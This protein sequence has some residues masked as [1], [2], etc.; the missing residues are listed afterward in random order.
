MCLTEH[1]APGQWDYARRPSRRELAAVRLLAVP[2]EE[3]SVK[4]RTGPPD[5]GHS[6][7]A[8][9]GRWAAAASGLPVT[10]LALYEPP[11]RTDDSHPGLP[12]DFARQLAELVAAGHRGDAVELYQT[13]AVG[14]PEDVVARA[15]GAARGRRATWC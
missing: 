2:L 8:A 15:S 10:K 3:A 12:A 5:D 13:K 6:P 7:D 9:L 1:V 4:V 11:F 14:I